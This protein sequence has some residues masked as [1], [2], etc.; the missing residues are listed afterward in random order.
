MKIKKDNK[1]IVEPEQECLGFVKRKCS[2]K[3]GFIDIKP[4]SLLH[5]PEI[6]LYGFKY[7]A[8]QEPRIEDEVEDYAQL[9]S[10]LT[11]AVNTDKTTSET[12]FPDFKCENGIIEHFYVTASEENKKGSEDKIV[13]SSENKKMEK[14]ID[15]DFQENNLKESY[16][17]EYKQP[18]LSYENFENSFKKNWKKHLDSLNKYKGNKENVCFLIESKTFGLTMKIKRR[19]EYTL[20]ITTGRIVENYTNKLENFDHILLGRCKS[21]LEY[22]DKFKNDVHYVIFVS[23]GEVEIL[24]TEYAKY[25]S[26]LLD[27]YEISPA[28]IIRNFVTFEHLF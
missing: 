3:H 25:I 7:D 9:Y 23:D 6:K 2:N 22:I 28:E 14:R 1:N 17:S 12:N 5:N 20:G 18:L 4:E 27:E 16:M 8:G 19:Q 13:E 10:L 11:T 15:K 26:E 21:V 24:K